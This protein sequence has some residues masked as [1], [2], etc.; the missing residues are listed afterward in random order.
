MGSCRLS[1][2]IPAFNEAQRLPPTL[3][4]VFSF[5]SGLGFES[6]VIVVDDGSSDGTH[7][8]VGPPARVLRNEE[9]HG[10]G[11]AVRQGMLAA[12]GDVRIFMDADLC[13]PLE[14]ISRVIEQV[15][16][17]QDLVIGS[18]GV[19]GA[20]VSAGD[21]EYRRTMGRVFNRCVQMLA[22]RGIQDTQCGFKGFRGEVAQDL[23]SRQKLDGFAFDVEILFLARKLGYH[24]LE[25]P[26][27]WTDAEG[28]RIRPF[29]DGAKMLL[30][31]LRVRWLH[32]GDSLESDPRQTDSTDGDEP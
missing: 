21:K 30:D 31:V 25:L 14:F 9:N 19:A 18:R 24:I 1:I 27:T 6:E 10:K 26:V 12:T 13:V 23:F 32:R 15:D 11:F 2:I 16:E 22:I 4:E 17:G 28:S 29:I 7:E 3:E 20:K 8:E 5:A